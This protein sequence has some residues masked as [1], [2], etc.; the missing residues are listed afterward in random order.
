MKASPQKYIAIILISFNSANGTE[1][2]FC[3]SP[4]NREKQDL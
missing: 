3:I 4:S 2:Y 1:M